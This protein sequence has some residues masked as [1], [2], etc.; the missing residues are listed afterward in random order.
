MLFVRQILCPTYRNQL[1]PNKAAVTLTL[2]LSESYF[3]DRVGR[4]SGICLL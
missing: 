2:Q 4:Y 3:A 1:N